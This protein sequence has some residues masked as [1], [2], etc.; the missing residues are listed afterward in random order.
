MCPA[1]EYE[2][3]ADN[4]DGVLEGT[5]QYTQEEPT[6]AGS[7]CQLSGH[8]RRHD[9][10]WDSKDSDQLTLCRILGSQREDILLV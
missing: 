9:H 6:D 7:D 3:E 4:L 2:Q 10:H 8:M 5:A 1:L